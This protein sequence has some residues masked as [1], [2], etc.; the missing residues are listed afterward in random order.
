M[1]TLIIH[2]LQFKTAYDAVLFELKNNREGGIGEVT[3]Y[4]WRGRRVAG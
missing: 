2:R 4:A 3:E 1:Q